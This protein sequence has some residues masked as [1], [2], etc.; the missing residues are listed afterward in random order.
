MVCGIWCENGIH[1]IF[2]YFSCASCLGCLQRSASI[3]CG[4]T[5][6]HQLAIRC[7]LVIGCFQLVLGCHTG[8]T[9]LFVAAVDFLENNIF[10]SDAL[11]RKLVI[12]LRVYTSLDSRG[13]CEI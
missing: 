8:N 9:S 2:A 5:I 11:N 3:P 10:K 13:C 7:Q 4:W 6:G 12:L 1:S